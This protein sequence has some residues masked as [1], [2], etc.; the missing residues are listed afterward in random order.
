MESQSQIDNKEI[1]LQ[2]EPKGD[3]SEPAPETTGF[4]TDNGP[5]VVK[6]VDE[7]I[8]LLRELKA[9]ITYPA[10]KSSGNNFPCYN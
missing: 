6:G 1:C 3:G 8:S 2:P 9:V 10:F 7:V 5:V 4:E